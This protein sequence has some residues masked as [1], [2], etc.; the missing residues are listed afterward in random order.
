MTPLPSTTPAP[1]RPAR[2]PGPSG[3]APA[4]PAGTHPSG[5]G[6]GARAGRPRLLALAEGFVALFLEVEAGRRPR[7]HLA[8][9]MT[10]MLYAR[11]SDVWVCG[12]APG[13]VLGVRVTGSGPDGVDLVAIVRRGS[14]CGA[15]ALHMVATKRGWLV[16]DVALPEHGPL[17]HPP[18][19][20]PTDED[21]EGNELAA[22][23]PVARPRNAVGAASA[24]WFQRV[25]PG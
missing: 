14:R 9:V 10:P 11:L 21:D 4:G 17:P 20:V 8:G 16:D 2:P 7:A 25:G 19:P 6:D 1:A 23:P 18:Y 24:D 5:R 22:V 3:A 12:G 13:S 15:I